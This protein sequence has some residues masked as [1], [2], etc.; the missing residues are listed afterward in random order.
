M[1]LVLAKEGIEAML[2]RIFNNSFPTSKD[3][4]LCLYTNDH[5][6]AT[7][8]TVASYTEPVGGGYAAKTLTTGSWTVETG[9]DPRDIIYAAQTFIFTGPLTGNPDIVGAFIKDANGKFWWAQR[10][11]EAFTPTNNGDN[12]IVY[13]FYAQSHGTPT[14]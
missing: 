11:D 14:T 13:P 2:G 7:G 12:I 4:T 3:L 9:N 10:R 6:P 5:D 1:G 8:D